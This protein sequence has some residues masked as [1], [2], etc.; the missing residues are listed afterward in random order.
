MPSTYRLILLSGVGAGTEYPLEKTELQLG[1]DLSNDIVINDPEVSRRHAHL[2]LEGDGYILEDLGSTNGTFIR[3][4]RLAAPVV[5]RP[6]E[7]ITIGEKVNLKYEVVSSD[8]SATVVVQRRSADE[9]QP[10]IPQPMAPPMVQPIMAP[11]LIQPANI[12]PPPVGAPMQ[13]PIAPGM[14]PPPAKKKSKTLLI[15][16][17]LLGIIVV[18]CLIPIIILDVTKSWCAPGIGDILNLIF[19]AGTC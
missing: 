14:M 18:F 3:G 4:Q 5:L 12:A 2:T 16:L 1:R 6:G 15:I 8:Q 17:I 9:V 11:P 19:G 13:P 7:A 10:P